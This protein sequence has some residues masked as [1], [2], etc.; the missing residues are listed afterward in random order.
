MGS[1]GFLHRIP[2]F[3]VPAARLDLL[4]VR[5]LTCPEMSRNALLSENCPQ[6][7]QTPF[8][9]PSHWAPPAA[10]SPVALQAAS[11]AHLDLAAIFQKDFRGLNVTRA[12]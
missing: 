2:A 8:P 10:P 5:I 4:P 6:C 7:Q 9:R 3:V 12:A 11:T 1:G